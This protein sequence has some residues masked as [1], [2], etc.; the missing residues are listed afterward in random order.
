[1]SV[2]IRDTRKNQAPNVIRE[3]SQESEEMAV[4]VREVK[5]RPS[6][7]TYG[8]RV[9]TITSGRNGWNQSGGDVPK[10]TKS[11]W[12]QSGR[13]VPK[14]TK[15]AWNQSGGDVQKSTKSGAKKQKT[16]V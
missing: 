2:S 3:K 15:S 11:G 5:Q 10:S 1:M 8:R 14:S 13:D 16:I 7:H 12:N 9:P 4:E 6:V